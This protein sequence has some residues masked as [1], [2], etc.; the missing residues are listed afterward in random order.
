MTAEELPTNTICETVVKDGRFELRGRVK[1]PIL[2]TLIT[3]NIASLAEGEEI[4]WTY[5]PV[6]ADNV[7]MCVQASHYDSIPL[8]A[9]IT[10]DF[11]ITGGRVQADFNAYNLWKLQG[12]GDKDF[13]LTHPSSVISVYLAN[14]MLRMGYNLTREEVEELERAITEVPDDPER[15][16]VF[17]RNCALAK[18]TA[19]GYPI[20]N[21]ALNDMNGNACGLSEII[22]TGKYV[23]VDFWSTWCGPCM[24]AIPR[25]QGVAGTFPGRTRGNRNFMRYGFESLE[26]CYREE[27]SDVGTVRVHETGVQGFFGKVSGWWCSLFFD[28]G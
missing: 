21:L 13:I 19:K 22:P 15:L 20:V 12:K 14:K 2:C 4:R 9:P 3:T 26:S 5:T 1:G 18:V 11:K 28:I 8:D 6:F 23:L 27:A 24:A 25:Y 16:A 10:S 17:R 7:E